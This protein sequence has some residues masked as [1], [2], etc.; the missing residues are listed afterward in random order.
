MIQ[1]NKASGYLLYAIGEIVLVML[2]ILAA[3]QVDNWNEERKQN[4]L[5]RKILKDIKADLEHNKQLL[6]E[7]IDF[8]KYSK[9][10][11][12][13]I[14]KYVSNE[15]PF[16][17]TVIKSFNTVYNWSA[18]YLSFSAYESLKSKGIDI[19]GNTELKSAIS[20]LFEST[21]SYVIEDYDRAE[22]QLSETLRLPTFTKYVRFKNIGDNENENFK[23]Y[24]VAPERMKQDTVF[25]NILSQSIA[26]RGWGIGEY[27][28][29]LTDTEDVIKLIEQELEK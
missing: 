5:S 21:F 8:N 2:G 11:L 1:K 22:W 29:A 20:K 28:D 26:F 17:S 16:D 10:N 27:E 3:I 23:S 13:T 18:P 15:I 25:I 24:P 9:D 14:Y 12:K 6:T 19:I 4:E 7:T